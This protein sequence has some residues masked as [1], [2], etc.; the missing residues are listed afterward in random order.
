MAAR[1]SLAGG[2]VFSASA[3]MLTTM[4]VE[5]PKLSVTD[6][7]DVSFSSVVRW[8]FPKDWRLVIRAPIFLFLG[9]S[10]VATGVWA[11]T[12]FLLWIAPRW[13]GLNGFLYPN[14]DILL[15]WV[16]GLLLVP[17]WLEYQIIK[18]F[19]AVN[20]IKGS[21]WKRSAFGLVLLLAALFIPLIRE[22]TVRL[23]RIY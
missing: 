5:N 10:F 19:Y 14:F 12:D 7:A 21:A 9:Y 18:Y 11:F 6:Q 20:Q 22:I 2:F 4:T 17:T 23:F 13:K 1:S 8:Y 3:I 16:I 15:A